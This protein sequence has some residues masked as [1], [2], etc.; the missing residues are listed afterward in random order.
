MIN[1]KWTIVTKITT[2]PAKRTTAAVYETPVTTL[3]RKI[4]E[5]MPP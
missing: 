1:R 2:N 3:L 4:I 5:P